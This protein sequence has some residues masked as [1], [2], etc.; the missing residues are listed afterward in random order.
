MISVKGIRRRKFRNGFNL[1]HP[2]KRA[3]VKAT[4]AASL[5]SSPSDMSVRMLRTVSVTAK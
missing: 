5:P 3:G 1:D 4:V 2:V